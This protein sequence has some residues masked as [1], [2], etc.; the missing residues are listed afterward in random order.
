MVNT[1][2]S[3][4]RKYPCGPHTDMKTI[5]VSSEAL[6]EYLIE[7]CPYLSLSVEGTKYCSKKINEQ[8]KL[9]AIEKDRC[10]SDCPRLYA[11]PTRC[12]L[13]DCA[14]IKKLIKRFKI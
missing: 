10:P 14:R 4:S 1:F 5:Q 7:S 12:E 2:I 3:R 8:C 13:S 6:A 11:T 9:Y